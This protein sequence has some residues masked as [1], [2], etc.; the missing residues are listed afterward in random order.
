MP[1]TTCLPV[2]VIPG[3]RLWSTC[4]WYTTVRSL[5]RIYPGESFAL[6]TEVGPNPERAFLE[7]RHM[8]LLLRKR[9]S[10]HTGQSLMSKEVLLSGSREVVCHTGRR[11]V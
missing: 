6:R 9:S 11:A 10:C 4:T 3:L 7:L 5:R 8:L 1:A 2:P